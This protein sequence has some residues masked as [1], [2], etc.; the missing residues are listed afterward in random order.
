MVEIPEDAGGDTLWVSAYA[1]YEKLS[2][3][4]QRFAETLTAKHRHVSVFR[5]IRFN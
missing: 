2:P 1:L 4:W 3:S 5:P